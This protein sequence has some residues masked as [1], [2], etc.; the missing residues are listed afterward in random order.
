MDVLVIAATPGELDWVGGAET[1]VVGIGP[2]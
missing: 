1:L 2:V